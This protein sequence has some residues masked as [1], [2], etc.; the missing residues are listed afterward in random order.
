MSLLPC[1]TRVFF[2]TIHPDFL[3]LQSSPGLLSPFLFSYLL[4]H[5]PSLTHCFCSPS[6]LPV[7]L[8]SFLSLPVILVYIYIYI[9]ISLPVL[10]STNW[11]HPM[12]ASCPYQVFTLYAHGYPCLYSFSLSINFILLSQP[13]Q[14]PTLVHSVWY[15]IVT[16]AHI[17]PFSQ[18]PDISICPPFLIS[19]HL[20]HLVFSHIFFPPHTSNAP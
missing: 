18:T 6:L 11:T 3:S 15:M 7:L 12:P 20:Q 8:P 14:L 4:I 5:S 1:M 17:L 9:Y 16:V 19:C 2:I 13:S 10:Q